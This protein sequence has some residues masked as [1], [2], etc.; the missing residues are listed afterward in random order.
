MVCEIAF[1]YDIIMLG[2]ASSSIYFPV[3]SM[4]VPD[5]LKQPTMFP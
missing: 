1:V 2:Y 5:T 3:R 4:F